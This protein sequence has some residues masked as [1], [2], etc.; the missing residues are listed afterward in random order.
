[1]MPLHVAAEH[2]NV[3]IVQFLLSKRVD[4]DAGDNQGVKPLH[5]AAICNHIEVG[6]PG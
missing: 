6:T 2:G 3:E 4:V 5:L 1:M